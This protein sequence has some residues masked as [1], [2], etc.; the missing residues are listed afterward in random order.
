[1]EDFVITYCN[2]VISKY[3]NNQIHTLTD[4][5][6]RLSNKNTSAKEKTKIN[7]LVKPLEVL[8]D[9]KLKK[10]QTFPYYGKQ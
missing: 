9:A 1:M 8:I 5:K 4:L 10:C 3:L 6:K 7:N 2:K